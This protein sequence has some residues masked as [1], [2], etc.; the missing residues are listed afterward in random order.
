MNSG[1]V[2]QSKIAL[3][4]DDAIQFESTKNANAFKDFYSD[5]PR[6]Q[7]RKL[8]VTLNKFNNNSIK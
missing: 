4:K 7:V 3:K 6:N 8:P 5:L 2:N 1:K